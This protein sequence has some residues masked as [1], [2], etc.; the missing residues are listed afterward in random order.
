[1][2][3]AIVMVVIVASVT[4]GFVLNNDD[5]NIDDRDVCCCG[6]RLDR[7]RLVMTMVCAMDGD[8]DSIFLLLPLHCQKMKLTMNQ[9]DALFFFIN[10]VT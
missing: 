10:L 3:T 4:G 6:N 8:K 2:L 5:G 1:M 9:S 7:C